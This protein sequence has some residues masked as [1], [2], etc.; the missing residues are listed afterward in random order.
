[1]ADGNNDIFPTTLIL[2]RFLADWR[3]FHLFF[4]FHV[5]D[6]ETT[7]MANS[8]NTK[9]TA[10][11]VTPALANVWLQSAGVGRYTVLL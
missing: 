5:E 3:F 10:T 11:A 1:M 4:V 6:A 7:S 8:L 9:V 2:L